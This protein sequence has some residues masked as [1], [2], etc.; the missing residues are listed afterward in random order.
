[1]IANVPAEMIH[2]NLEPKF[3]C[4]CIDHHLTCLIGG[5]AP[6]QDLYGLYLML[7]W[8]VHGELLQPKGVVESP[9]GEGAA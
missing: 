4:M 2:R 6:M 9:C 7:Q 8:A 1:M 5:G 3:L